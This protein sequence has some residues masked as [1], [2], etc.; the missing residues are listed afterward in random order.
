M[1]PVALAALG[2]AAYGVFLVATMPAAFAIA[3]AARADGLVLEDVSGTVWNGSARATLSQA[4]PPVTLDRLAWRF[5][6]AALLRA[7]LGYDVTSTDPRLQGTLRLTHGFDGIAAED[8][9]LRAQAALA[10]AAMPLAAAWRPAGDI[11]L[12]APR[13]AWNGRDEVRGEATAEWRGATLSLPDAKALGSYRAVLKGDG[14]P[15]RI[16]LTTLDGAL[17][18]RGEGTLAPPAF[19]FNG[20]ARAQGPQADAVAPVLDLLGPRRADGSREIAVRLR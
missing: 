9:K 6:P 5:A 19:T 3:H 4:R 14:G 13:L 10:S 7:R 2:V 16:T 18:L 15:A 12:T 1:R 11:T 8:V 20:E 17:A